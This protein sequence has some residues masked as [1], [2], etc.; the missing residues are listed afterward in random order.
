MSDSL[1]ELK[2]YL[3]EHEVTLVAISKTKTPEEIL[4]VYH[5]GQRIF[6]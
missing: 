6:G 1:K 3:G 4:R 5:E 2:K